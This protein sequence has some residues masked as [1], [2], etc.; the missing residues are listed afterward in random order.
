MPLNRTPLT[1]NQIVAMANVSLQ[2]N[3][4]LTGDESSSPVAPTV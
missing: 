1:G 4:K 2:R 3:Y